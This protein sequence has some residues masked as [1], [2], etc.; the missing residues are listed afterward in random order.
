MN[1]C[2]TKKSY[3][4]SFTEFSHRRQAYSGSLKFTLSTVILRP[5]Q[6]ILIHEEEHEG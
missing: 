1:I 3:I 6:I 4:L 5:T 2:D